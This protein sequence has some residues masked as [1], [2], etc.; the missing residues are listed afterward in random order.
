MQDAPRPLD[1]LIRQLGY[2]GLVPQAFA[3]AMLIDGNDLRWI[4]SAG[5]FGYAA[6]IF[7]FL[8]GVWWGLA[9]QSETPP[10]WIYFAAVTPSLL[11]LVAYL[12]WT[13]GWE[14]PTMS[15]W[16]LAAMIA[17]SPLVDRAMARSIAL[18]TGWIA[19]RWQLSL[20]LAG[21]TAI[22]A[23]SQGWSTLAI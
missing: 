8:G 12:P 9:M 22:L 7:S 2:A 19:L 21:L 5:G 18:P 17:L 3:V 10:R 1:P 23:L 13:F 11:S 6:F 4:A 14:W 20:G 16:F 15:L